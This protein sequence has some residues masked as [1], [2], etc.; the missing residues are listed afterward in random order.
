MCY[1]FSIWASA[2]G[3]WPHE[4]KC[5]S[6]SAAW[7][8]L[9]VVCLSSTCI[10]QLWGFQQDVGTVWDF[11]LN[12]TRQWSGH[13]CMSYL[14]GPPRAEMGR[15]T[16]FPPGTQAFLASHL[17]PRP[18]VGVF[19]PRSASSPGYA[20][21][22]EGL[23]VVFSPLEMSVIWGEDH[24]KPLRRPLSY[25][26][27]PFRRFSWPPSWEWEKQDLLRVWGKDLD[28]W[29]HQGKGNGPQVTQ[30]TMGWEIEKHF[31]AISPPC[32]SNYVLIMYLLCILTY[33]VWC[34]YWVPSNPILAPGAFGESRWNK[35]V[36]DL[37]DS[38]ADW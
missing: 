18:R 32:W 36:H 26:W 1:L 28:V 6:V 7:A 19:S 20:L 17:A 21:G 12:N 38:C 35:S 2:S 37:T 15:R 31:F 30:S 22:F 11:H 5:L 3:P 25:W 4:Q 16:N 34:L 13:S 9:Q 14:R 10:P 24:L 8:P 27:A 29:G 23:P 33:D